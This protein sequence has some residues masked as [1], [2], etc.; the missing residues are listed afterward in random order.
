MSLRPPGRHWFLCS[1][2]H[3]RRIK[4]TPSM[5]RLFKATYWSG[6]WHWKEK[7]LPPV[8]GLEHERLLLTHWAQRLSFSFEHWERGRERWEGLTFSMAAGAVFKLWP[9][10]TSMKTTHD[11]GV[12]FK[13]QNSNQSSCR[14]R[15]LAG[16]KK[17]GGRGIAEGRVG[18][19]PRC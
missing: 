4:A 8:K 17:E 1:F 16:E 19:I 6:L 15:K 13:T 9:M 10:T 7:W 14:W 2:G 3:S 5:P 12:K 11:M 18:A